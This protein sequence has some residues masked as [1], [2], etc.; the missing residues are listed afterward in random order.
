[1]LAIHP[2]YQ[3]R[4][5]D[6]LHA[7][8]S[9]ADE[10]V[11]KEHIAKL[12]LMD[13][14][15]KE[16]LRL[17]PPAPFIVRQATDDLPLFDGVIPKG[18]QFI[19]SLYNTHRNPTIWGESVNE[20]YPERFLPENSAN[21]HPYQYIP[22]SAGPRNC[23][24]IRYAKTSLF[25]SLAYLLRNFKFTTDLK[26]PDVKIRTGVLIKITNKD[27]VRLERRDW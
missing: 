16:T 26:L 5:V 12:S 7:V 25:I 2:E 18:A 13:L 10:P 3:D 22:F 4:L 27:P 20:F 8:F 17:Y 23:I 11:T 1:M 14:V 24:G 21:Y 15:I 9:D 19:I 6:E